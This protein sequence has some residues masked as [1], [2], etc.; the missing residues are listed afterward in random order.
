[1]NDLLRPY[2]VL[3]IVVYLDDI[4]VYSKI[5]QD[6]I[7]HLRQVFSTLKEHKLDGKLEK[8]KFF[9]PRVVFLGYEVSCD[10]I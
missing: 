8:C 10:G 5:K 1:M 6:R 3:F 2:I 9:V 7:H 4:L